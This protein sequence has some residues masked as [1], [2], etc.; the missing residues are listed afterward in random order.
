M[1]HGVLSREGSQKGK[2]RTFPLKPKIRLNLRIFL[3]NT[4][5]PKTAQNHSSDG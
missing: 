4:M 2:T 1:N 5:L 3:A